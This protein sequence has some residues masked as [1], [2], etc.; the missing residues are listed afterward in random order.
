[1]LQQMQRV[2][3]ALKMKVRNT[4]LVYIP[5]VPMIKRLELLRPLHKMD[6]LQ[7]KRPSKRW[8]RCKNRINLT[9]TTDQVDL[10]ETSELFEL[11]NNQNKEKTHQ[12]WWRKRTV[13]MSLVNSRVNWTKIISFCKII[14]M[15]KC[16]D[17]T[18]FPN[19]VSDLVRLKVPHVK[20]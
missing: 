9:H 11:E 5:E 8:P 1:M 7:I 2:F 17:R 13:M 19:K 6:N 14:I 15:I 4:L 10:L 20:K 3:I 16:K 12:L 18:F